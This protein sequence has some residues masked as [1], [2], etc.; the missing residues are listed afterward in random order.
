MTHRT[1]QLNIGLKSRNRLFAIAVVAPAMF[2]IWA[3]VWQ[4][5]PPV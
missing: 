3:T 4:H 2:V 1:L 5:V